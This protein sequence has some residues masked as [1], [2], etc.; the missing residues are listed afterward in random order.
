MGD[1]SPRKS[2]KSPFS[3]NAGPENP[4]S[5]YK[6]AGITGRFFRGWLFRLFGA[7]ASLGIYF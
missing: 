7:I 2:P 1:M 4:R 6:G 5:P 3:G